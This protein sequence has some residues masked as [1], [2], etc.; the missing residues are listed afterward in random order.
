M[1][2]V[3]IVLAAG[4]GKRMGGNIKKQYMLLCE[5]PILY[6]SLKA[7]Q[8]S[9]I[10]EIILVTSKD[11]IEFV[12]ND[13]IVRFGFSKVTNIVEGGKE[14]YNSVLN[15][16]NAIEDA[17]YVFIHDGARPLVDNDILK[18]GFEAVKKYDACVVGMPSKDTVKIATEDGFVDITPN[19]SLVWNIQTPQIFN[20]HMI[21]E[22]Y[23]MVVSKEDELKSKGINIT[24]DAMVLEHYNHHPIRLVEGSYEN[25]K[26]TTI[27]DLDVAEKY[28]KNI[29]NNVDIK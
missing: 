15:G 3:A 17:D 29:K 20:F 28:L 14:R 11:D 8:D 2:T 5:K 6:Y 13:I 12:K 16:L 9:F 4:S 24:D 18:R 27:D 26:V 10:D 1:K 25:I 21:K 7:F 23:I 22:A 19:R